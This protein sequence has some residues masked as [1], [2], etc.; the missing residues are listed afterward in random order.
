MRL[1]YKK[2]YNGQIAVPPNL[3][4]TNISP[5]ISKQFMETKAVDALIRIAG[6][7]EISN[8]VVLLLSNKSPSVLVHISLIDGGIVSR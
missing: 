4:I 7:E 5:S 1:E 6:P 8:T 3:V 2:T